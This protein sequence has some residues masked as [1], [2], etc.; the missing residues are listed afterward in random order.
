MEP[1]FTWNEQTGVS[2]CTITDGSFEYTGFATCHPDDLDFQS[3]RTGYEIAYRRAEIKMLKNIKKEQKLIYDTLNHL[4]STINHS[5]KYNPESY[6]AR[7]IQRELS[8]A[9]YDY[10]SFS[11]IL[12]ERKQSLNNYIA[13][14]ETFYKK[15]RQGRNKSI[16][17]EEKA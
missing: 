7:A 3:E 11:E 8:N 1:K 10:F 12:K 15:I 13:M 17:Q 14:K 9:A 16:N 2:S 6:E 5:K 4:Y